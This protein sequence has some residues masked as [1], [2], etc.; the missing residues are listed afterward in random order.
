MVA[1]DSPTRVAEPRSPSRLRAART[2]S[3]RAT[4][5]CSSSRMSPVVQFLR[6]QTKDVLAAETRDRSFQDGGAR[7]PFAHDPGECRDVSRASDG[8]S[9]SP[10]VL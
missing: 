9:I 1:S 4:C 10:S 8:W 6:A 2:S 3:F 7:G 5:A